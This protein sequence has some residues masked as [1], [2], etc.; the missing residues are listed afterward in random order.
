MLL[1][2]TR[3]EH[4]SCFLSSCQ[5]RLNVLITQFIGK[6]F[7]VFIVKTRTSDFS[8]VISS[9]NRICIRCW[10]T[11][12]LIRHIVTRMV[13]TIHN[14][15][16][17][18][19]QNL[20]LINGRFPTISNH[21]S[22]NYKNIFHKTEFQTVILR[23]WLGLNP[24]WFKSYEIKCKYF[25]FHFFFQFCKKNLLVCVKFF[26]FSAIFVFYHVYFAFVL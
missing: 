17:P 7:C 23:C 13:K 9:A 26:T 20:W 2:G 1:G 14:L 6:G 19:A 3:D 16:E 8:S 21:F 10:K 5:L 11:M 18:D 22:T 12:V 24:N 15:I 25:C 4:F